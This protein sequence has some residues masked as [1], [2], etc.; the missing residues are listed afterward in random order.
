[1]WAALFTRTWWGEKSESEE[2]WA[3][4]SKEME[5]GVKKQGWEHDN[6]DNRKKKAEREED[7]DL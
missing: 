1:M 2:G 7:Q 6:G 5:H 4:E 3:K